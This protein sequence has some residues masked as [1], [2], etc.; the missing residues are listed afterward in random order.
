VTARAGAR[1]PPSDGRHLGAGRLTQSFTA[2]LARCSRRPQE[3]PLVRKRSDGEWGGDRGVRG[4]TQLGNARK[5]R[6][7]STWAVCR[8]GSGVVKRQVLRSPGHGCKPIGQGRSASFGKMPEG[9][10]VRVLVVDVVGSRDRSVRIGVELRA[11]SQDKVQKGGLVRSNPSK[12]LTRATVVRL[13]QRANCNGRRRRARKRPEAPYTPPG[14]TGTRSETVRTHHAKLSQRRHGAWLCPTPQGVG[15][16]W[17]KR[18]VDSAQACRGADTI[19]GAPSRSSIFSHRGD[20]S[21]ERGDGGTILALAVKLTP[22][23]RE[24]CGAPA[25]G[26]IR[27]RRT[28]AAE[29]QGASEVGSFR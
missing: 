8:S 18:H 1:A 27:S 19:E 23:A 10:E 13:Q 20:G 4:T 21:S 17:L 25:G 5:K 28:G 9:D 11:W 26:R 16:E 14:E 3:V 24:A 22:H 7:V 2:G 29:R 15:S 12:P 6:R